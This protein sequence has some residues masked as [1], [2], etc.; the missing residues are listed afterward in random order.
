MFEDNAST[1][2][3]IDEDNAST[4]HRSTEVEENTS[5]KN[6]MSFCHLVKRNSQRFFHEVG[7]SC[8]CR[9]M[10]NIDHIQSVS[11]GRLLTNSTRSTSKAHN[12]GMMRVLLH[13][14]EFGAKTRTVNSAPHASEAVVAVGQLGQHTCHIACTPCVPTTTAVIESKK[15][16]LSNAVVM[17]FSHAP[18]C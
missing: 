6:Q 11:C 3:M 2:T 15:S 8:S 16:S 1:N 10:L 7:W 4:K 5:S 17:F 18:L 14:N 9:K 13:G 12:V